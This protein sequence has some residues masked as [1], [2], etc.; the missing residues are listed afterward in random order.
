MSSKDPDEVSVLWYKRRGEKFR[1]HLSGLAISFVYHIF[2][3]ETERGRLAGLHELL[4]LAEGGVREINMPSRY[5]VS[6]PSV[7]GTMESTNL[8]SWHSLAIL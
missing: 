8:A 1:I 4:Q 7:G 3:V 6:V 5:Q 2:I